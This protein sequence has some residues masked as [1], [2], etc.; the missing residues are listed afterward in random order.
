MDRRRETRKTTEGKCVQTLYEEVWIFE[1][2][3]RF[4]RAT[5]ARVLQPVQLSSLP[6]KVCT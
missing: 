4:S 2:S 6:K 5:Y 3:V 1:A